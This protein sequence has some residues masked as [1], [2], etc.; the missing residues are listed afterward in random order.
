VLD[1]GRT[2]VA[3]S[4][5]RSTASKK[6]MTYN[7]LETMFADLTDGIIRTAAIRRVM[8]ACWNAGSLPSAAEIA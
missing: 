5:A 2:R 3:A 1:D 4:N 7:K 8:D 6:P